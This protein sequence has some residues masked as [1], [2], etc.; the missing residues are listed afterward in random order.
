VAA[1][2]R[3]RRWSR[4]ACAEAAL[5][6]R[7]WPRTGALGLSACAFAAAERAAQRLGFDS[8]DAAGMAGCS[9]DVLSEAIE[10]LE[11]E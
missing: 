7:V 10:D 5:Q 3:A 1:R 11:S 9:P 6:L 2:L 8:W 4:E